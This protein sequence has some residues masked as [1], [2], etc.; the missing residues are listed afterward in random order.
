MA[1]AIGR[2]RAG[3]GVEEASKSI[4]HNFNEHVLHENSF[5]IYNTP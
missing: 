4:F 3:Q 2:Y 1:R 5:Y